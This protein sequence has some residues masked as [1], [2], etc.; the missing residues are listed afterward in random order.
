MS[1]VCPSGVACATIALASVL[2]AP[3]RF[4]ITTGWPQICESPGAIVRALM[5]VALPGEKPTTMRTDFVGNFCDCAIAG[6]AAK[7][8]V[9]SAR[10]TVRYERLTTRMVPILLVVCERDLIV[11]DVEPRSLPSARSTS[12]ASAQTRRQR[13]GFDRDAR[14]VHRLAGHGCGRCIV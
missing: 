14:P 2:P 3:E 1:S 12:C 8:I 5:S 13:E 11:F 7:P 9:P 10:S 4:S 6:C